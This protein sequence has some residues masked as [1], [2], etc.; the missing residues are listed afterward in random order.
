MSPVFLSS[1]HLFGRFAE[2]AEES[3]REASEAAAE[4]SQAARAERGC[5]EDSYAAGGDGSD[6][7]GGGGDD[8]DTGD[9]TPG[10]GLAALFVAVPS[11]PIPD[12]TAEQYPEFDG[13]PFSAEHKAHIVESKKFYLVANTI[14]P[15][16]GGTQKVLPQAAGAPRQIKGEGGGQEPPCGCKA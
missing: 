3:E 1:A 14:P 2:E 15:I 13:V 12:V 7:G 4:A 16:K 10:A 6:D 5:D 11:T 9:A 8:A